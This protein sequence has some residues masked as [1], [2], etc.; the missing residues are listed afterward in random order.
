M[1]RKKKE[2]M[3]RKKKRGNWW[4]SR[5]VIPKAKNYISYYIPVESI[6]IFLN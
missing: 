3:I 2:K 5:F 6:L 4:S 1:I